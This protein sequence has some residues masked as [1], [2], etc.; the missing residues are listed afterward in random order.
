[1][2][3]VHTMNVKHA[4]SVVYNHCKTTLFYCYLIHLWISLLYCGCISL[5]ECALYRSHNQLPVIYWLKFNDFWIYIE[6]P[7]NLNNWTSN[8]NGLTSSSFV[9]VT[10]NES[11]YDAH[12]K[13]IHF[14][15]ISLRYNLHAKYLHRYETVFTVRRT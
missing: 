13:M 2:K 6:S 10:L 8:Q 14:H 5:T 1:M 11:K 4:E 15:L 9:H 12:A 7:C 3:F